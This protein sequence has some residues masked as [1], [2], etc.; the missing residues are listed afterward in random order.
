M[1]K[2]VVLYYYIKLTWMHSGSTQEAGNA[3][4]T[5]KSTTQ[6]IHRLNVSSEAA[7]F[8]S[9]NNQNNVLHN[10]SSTV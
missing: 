1:R 4:T 2:K 5:A 6:T 7:L 8:S 9:T 10:N 3:E